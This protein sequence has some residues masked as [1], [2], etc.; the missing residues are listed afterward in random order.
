MLKPITLVSCIVFF[1]LAT[2]SRPLHAQPHPS[3]AALINLDRAENLARQAAEKA[4]GG[5]QNYRA[6]DSMYGTGDRSPH[7][8]DGHGSWTFTFKGHRPG[9]VTPTVESVVTVSRDGFVNIDYNG[10]I[11]SGS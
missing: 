4:N 6:E 1:A 9:S 2:N 5:L 8:Y 7:T 3:S 10:P 11:H